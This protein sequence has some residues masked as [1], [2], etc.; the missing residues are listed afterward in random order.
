MA[1]P[2]LSEKL[3]VSVRTIYRDVDTL[4]MAGVPIQ[5]TAGKRGGIS[6]MPGYT[7]DKS[8]L[9][10]S[11]QD[12]LLFALQSLRATDQNVDNLL[13][14]LGTAFHR[15]YTDWITV[16]FS[17][18]GLRQIDAERFEQ[19][20]TAILNNQ[21][22]RITYCGMSG[23]KSQRLIQ[24]IRLA[25]K[26]KNWYL[27]SFCQRA[28]DFRLFKI[29]RIIEVTPTNEHFTPYRSEDIP[30]LEIESTPGL[31]TALQLRF[32]PQIAYRVY[33][34]FDRSCIEEEPSG[35][36]RVNT[37]FPMDSWVASYLFSYGTDVEILEPSHLREEVA[38]YAEKISNHHKT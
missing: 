29:G 27:Q 15:S 9:S 5:T 17:R 7:L 18:W 24:P 35:F 21:I 8:L 20:K 25:Y 26:D 33:D 22:L 19:L 28:D 2:E 6:L 4:S 31:E 10:S 16:D 1:A 23:E 14:K 36:L 30:P 37:M 38:A 11:E 12:Q 3:E 34:E 13:H 32:S